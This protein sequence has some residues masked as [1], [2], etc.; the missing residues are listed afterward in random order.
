MTA[1]H[2][3]PMCYSPVSNPGRRGE[4]CRVWPFY[5]KS[6]D[7]PETYPQTSVSVSFAQCVTRP[8]L[9]TVEARR[10]GMSLLQP[11][12]EMHRTGNLTIPLCLPT[13][14]SD[15]TA[16]FFIRIC[17]QITRCLKHSLSVHLYHSF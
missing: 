10:A 6:K 13:A 14:L 17:F 9:D 3:Q 12:G 2:L 15:E 8:P 16:I 7:F 11:P 4:D 5:E 1:P